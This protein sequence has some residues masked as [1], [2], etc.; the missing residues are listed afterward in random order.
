MS[1]ELDKQIR[2][3]LTPPPTSPLVDDTETKIRMLT[4]F[5]NARYVPKATYDKKINGAKHKAIADMKE[6]I[7]E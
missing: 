2:E 7:S 5:I 3:I 1:K 6:A 4:K